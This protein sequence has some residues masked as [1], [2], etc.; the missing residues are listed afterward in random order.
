MKL[1]LQDSFAVAIAVQRI[2]AWNEF[3]RP[4][5]TKTYAEET[6]GDRNP[7]Q[8]IKSKERSLGLGR[9]GVHLLGLGIEKK[10]R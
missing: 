4:Q 2:K 8:R 9:T 7:L 6:D 1:I 5:K 10:T 3:A